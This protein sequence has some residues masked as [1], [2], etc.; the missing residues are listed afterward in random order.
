MLTVLKGLPLAYNKDLQE[1]KEPVFD[2]FDT[3]SLCLEAMDGML[4]TAQFNTENM[5]T[6]AE[7]GFTTATA[8]ADWLVMSLNI[9]FRQAHHIT[10]ALVK[11][12]ETRGCSLSELPLDVLQAQEPRITDDIYRVLRL[13]VA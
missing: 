12:A 1:D 5:R 6:S 13:P 11:E 4:S 7:K 3:I 8:L 10:G 9:P 2:S